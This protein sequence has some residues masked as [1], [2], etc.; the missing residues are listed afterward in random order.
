[1]AQAERFDPRGDFIHAQ[2][3]ALAEIAAPAV[4]QPGGGIDL[5]HQADYPAPMVDLATERAE[6]LRR[7]EE[8]KDG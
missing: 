5:L 8:T 7:L 6:A 2:I 4:L 1:M 3:P